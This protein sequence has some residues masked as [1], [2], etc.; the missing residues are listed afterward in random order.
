MADAEEAKRRGFGD[1][2]LPNVE[3]HEV[4]MGHPASPLA[5][6]YSKEKSGSTCAPRRPARFLTGDFMTRC[7]F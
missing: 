3:K 1:G 6:R 4:R 7:G 2:A 5:S